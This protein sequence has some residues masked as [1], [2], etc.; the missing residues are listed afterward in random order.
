MSS[1]GFKYFENTPLNNITEF[2]NKNQDKIKFLIPPVSGQLIQPEDVVL[3]FSFQVNSDDTSPYNTPNYNSG[4]VAVGCDNVAGISSVIEKQEINNSSLNMLFESNPDIDFYTKMNRCA[5]ASNNDLK[6]GYYSCND[7]CQD[8]TQLVRQHFT[9]QTLAEDGVSVSINL[10]S[11]F[12]SK[13]VEMGVRTDAMQGLLIT[14]SLNSVNQALFN[15]YGNNTNQL[16]D[17]FNFTLRNVKLFGKSYTMNTPMPTSYTY[18][19]YNS[20]LQTLQSNNENI[21][22]E[23]LTQQTHSIVAVFQPNNSTRNNFNANNLNSNEVIGLKNYKLGL[24]GV[25]MPYDFN[26]VNT[27]DFENLLINNIYE[28]A[29]DE[30]GSAENILLLIASLR[31]RYRGVH[32]LINGKNEVASYQDLYNNNLYDLKNFR[33]IGVNYSYNFA[34]NTTNMVNEQFQLQ[35]ETLINTNTSKTVPSSWENTSFVGTFFV[36]HSKTVNLTNLQVT[37]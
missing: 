18:R 33:G 7:I 10:T 2:S 13:S 37:S 14:I 32:T 36:N 20:I 8:T 25:N 19:S 11:P 30:V 35:L 5:T 6:F 9:R 24:S 27:T 16:T 15:I 17:E 31:V 4:N 22:F 26:I 34:G 23:P 12:L 3:N 1:L 21:S 29:V 28:P